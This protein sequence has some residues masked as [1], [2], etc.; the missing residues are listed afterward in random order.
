[1]KTRTALTAWALGLL[2]APAA[3]AFSRFEHHQITYYAHEHVRARACPRGGP[4]LSPLC[5][6]AVSSDDLARIA[7]AVDH[8][9]YPRRL[10]PW[11]PDCSSG[12]REDCRKVVA[13]DCRD[14]RLDF[15]ACARRALDE[16]WER[17]G[18]RQ[19][20]WL[21]RFLA[22]HRNREHFR[23]AAC[24]SF[25]E[26]HERAI[27]LAEH[28]SAESLELA[29]VAESVAIHFLQDAL[30][31]GHLAA[32]RDQFSDW[33]AGAVHDR[34]N[35]GGLPVGVAHRACAAL[36]GLLVVEDLTAPEA[37][38]ERIPAE[39]LISWEAL[40]GDLAA[41]GAG[42]NGAGRTY[43]AHGDK[44]LLPAVTHADAR[45]HAATVFYLTVAALEDLYG[46]G[47]RDR[48][49]MFYDRPVYRRR[50]EP[51]GAGA[52]QAPRLGFAAWSDGPTDEKR[53]CDGRGGVVADGELFSYRTA[54]EPESGGPPPIDSIHMLNT[55]QVAYSTWGDARR[56]WELAWDSGARERLITVLAN[57]DED[58]A[59]FRRKYLGV[60]SWSVHHE[61]L[62]DNDV[63][64]LGL[65]ST[66]SW[67]ISKYRDF[68]LYLGVEPGVGYYDLDGDTTTRFRSSM[69]A[70]VGLS[71]VA[72]EALVEY[73]RSLDQGR[74]SED[75]WRWSMNLRLRLSPTWLP[76]SPVRRSTVAAGP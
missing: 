29:L 54:V 76:R 4:P 37:W 12:T 43:T 21:Y 42:C 71:V 64:G 72:A 19:R 10:A 68:D 75:E 63:I 13:A 55:V 32:P 14:D 48:L 73:G 36:P 27:D 35:R 65:L 45:V 34:Y 41:L 33:H 30:A 50:A 8:F 70:G 5:A 28:A 67:Q 11:P 40:R 74:S 6:A 25:N 24:V 53:V 66:Y 31:P 3:Q 51:P 52:R 60:G 61:Q 26:M 22:V 39:K 23:D 16:T 2:A 44:S 1:M 15:D 49:W 20:D 62:E 17:I 58:T 57:G 9:T 69:R 7:R 47:E 18:A 38:S 56:R 46:V 59:D